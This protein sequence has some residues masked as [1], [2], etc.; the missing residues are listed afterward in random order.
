MFLY[1]TA[2]SFPF[3]SKRNWL[4]NNATVNITILYK[5]WNNSFLVREEKETKAGREISL[6]VKSDSN[7]L[8]NRNA[9]LKLHFG[10]YGYIINTLVY[11]IVA[12]WPESLSPISL[13]TLQFKCVYCVWGDVYWEVVLLWVFSNA[14]YVCM[15][16]RLV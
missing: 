1:L 3:S 14:Y 5:Y 4:H 15:S 6:P 13:C 7:I 12:C 9:Y 16:A 2:I 10:Y 8:R 11:H